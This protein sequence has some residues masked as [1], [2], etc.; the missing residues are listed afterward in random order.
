MEQGR[1]ARDVAAVEAWVEAQ[2]RAGAEWAGLS[3]Q[4]REA[5][6]HAQDVVQECPTLSENRVVER[7]VLSVGRE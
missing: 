6:A 7:L 1:L 3:L 4:G 2:A 5:T